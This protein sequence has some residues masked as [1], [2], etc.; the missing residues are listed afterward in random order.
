[1]CMGSMGMVQPMGHGH[2]N[3]HNAM[4][5]AQNLKAKA[6][7]MDHKEQMKRGQAAQLR[8]QAMQMQMRGNHMGAQQ[9]LH[10]ATHADAHANHLDA[11]E[12]QLHAKANQKLVQGQMQSN[13]GI[14]GMGMGMAHPTGAM[15][16]M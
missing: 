6:A 15:S 1:M 4:G 10:R 8:N 7:M 9:L 11:K 5:Q 14:G 12:Q 2:V 13:L 16:G 3:H